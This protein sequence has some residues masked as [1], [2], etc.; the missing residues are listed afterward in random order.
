MTNNEKAYYLLEFLFA[1]SLIIHIL[2]RC[3]GI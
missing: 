2:F 3:L 1:I